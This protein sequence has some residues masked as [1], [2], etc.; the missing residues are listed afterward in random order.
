MTLRH[1]DES[2]FKRRLEDVLSANKLWGRMFRR[3]GG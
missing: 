3:G 1:Y 2:T